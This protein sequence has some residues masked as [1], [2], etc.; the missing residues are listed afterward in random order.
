VAVTAAVVF[1]RLV[2][3]RPIMG[4]TDARGDSKETERR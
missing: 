1:T 4:R 3:L 2:H